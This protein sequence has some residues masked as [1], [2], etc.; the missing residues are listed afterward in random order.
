MKRLLAVIALAAAAWVASAQQAPAPAAN[1]PAEIAAVEGSFDLPSDEPPIVGATRDWGKLY[2]G[3]WQILHLER[4]YAEGGVYA[5]QIAYKSLDQSILGFLARPNVVIDKA[6]GEPREKFPAV[7][8]CHDGS[9]G[10]TQPYRRAAIELAKRG[11]VVA[12][13]SYRGNN[14]IEG[15]SQG[16]R[17]LGK[18]EVIDVLQLAQLIRKEDYVDSLRMAIVGEGEGG[19]IASQAIGRSNIFQAAVLISPYLFSGMQ[20]YGYAGA[21]VFADLSTRIYG[22]RISQG[23]VLRGLRDR[24]S[25]RF[26]DKIRTPTLVLLHAGYGQEADLSRWL[27]ILERNGVRNNVLRY[28]GG[29]GFVWSSDPGTRQNAWDNLVRWIEAYAPP[30]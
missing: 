26:A 5:W 23:E 27:G 4:T 7:I 24:D 15:T 9:R 28:G 1:E 25:F 18:S 22:R 19:L 13:S 12:A 8:L 16:R 10:V 11:Y 2:I 14:G 3:T 21:R 29:R 17:E 30:N 20:Q 6:T